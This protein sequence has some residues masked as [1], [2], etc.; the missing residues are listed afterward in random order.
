LESGVVWRP[1]GGAPGLGALASG[2][3]LAPTGAPPAATGGADGAGALA[4]GMVFAPGGAGAPGGGVAGAAGGF[5]AEGAGGGAGALAAVGIG[6][7]GV[8]AG[9]V[10]PFAATGAVEP[11]GAT[12]P[13]SSG[14]ARNVMRTV[15]FFSGTV[16]VFVEGFGGSGGVLS[17]SAM[18]IETFKKSGSAI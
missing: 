8:G 3:V 17:E 9:A 7:A 18:V 15:S 2:M 4:S 6:G 1:A 10:L 13:V 14:R 12:G 11:F 16:D 5:G